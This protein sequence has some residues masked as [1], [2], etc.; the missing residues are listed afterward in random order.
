MLDGNDTRATLS[1][2]QRL[3]LENQVLP[4]AARWVRDYPPGSV[5]H[6]QGMQTL[7]YWGEVAE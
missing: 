7:R 6:R 2:D 1:L 5:L 3:V 4:T